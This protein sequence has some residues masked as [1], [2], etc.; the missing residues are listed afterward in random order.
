MSPA[1]HCGVWH[2]THAGKTGGKGWLQIVP[3]AQV[4]CFPSTLLDT[5]GLAPAQGLPCY[6]QGCLRADSNSIT[7]TDGASSDFRVVACHGASVQ[8]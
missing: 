5:D 3:D 8:S 2:C 6:P 1:Q 4:V 7:C